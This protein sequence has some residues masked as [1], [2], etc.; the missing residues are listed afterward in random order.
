MSAPLC[1]V[2]PNIYPRHDWSVLGFCTRCGIALPKPSIYL[3]H[4]DVAALVASHPTM[5]SRLRLKEGEQID[6]TVENG[7]WEVKKL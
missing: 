5:I 4:G 1:Q 6:V 3:S 7:L 2:G